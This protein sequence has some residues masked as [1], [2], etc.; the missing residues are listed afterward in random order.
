[1]HNA[2]LNTTPPV[3]SSYEM[4]KIVSNVSAMS[5]R[6][7]FLLL[8]LANLLI[9]VAILVFAA[10]FFPYKPFIPGKATF[11]AS[12]NGGQ[13]ASAPFDK[14]IFMVVDAL[15]RLTPIL[16]QR[17]SITLKQSVTLSILMIRASDSLKRE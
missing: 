12:K 10:G 7:S 16:H 3:F 1:M 6:L 11:Q 14:V 17:Q 8:T 13:S 4:I 15:R 2:N 5:R 9:P